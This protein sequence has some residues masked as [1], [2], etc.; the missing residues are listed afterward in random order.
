MRLS[1]RA[2]GYG[3][4]TVGF[5]NQRKWIDTGLVL[6]I[7]LSAALSGCVVV[8]DQR[9]DAGGVVMVAPPPPP[10]EVV[11]VAPA[12][13]YVWF[14]GYWNWVGGRHEWVAGS[15]HAPRPGY[16][17]VAHVWVRQGDGWRMR[18]GHWERG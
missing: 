7:A 5:M 15:W 1:R 12:P 17:W 4:H 6:S 10:V 14:P 3:L 11:G 18:P 8:P 2:I 9:H 16:H 13:G